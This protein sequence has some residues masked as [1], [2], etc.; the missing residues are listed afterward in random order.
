MKVPYAN[1]PGDA[2]T[3]LRLAIQVAPISHVTLN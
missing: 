1:A 3:A 2:L